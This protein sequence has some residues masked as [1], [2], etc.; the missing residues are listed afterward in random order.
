MRRCD[1]FIAFC[2]SMITNSAVMS[3]KKGCAASHPPPPPVAVG[4][5]SGSGSWQSHLHRH[6]SS[7]NGNG[8]SNGNMPCEASPDADSR[9]AGGKSWKLVY[10]YGSWRLEARSW[11][12]TAFRIAF[13]QDRG[14]RIEDQLFLSSIY[15]LVSSIQH[16]LHGSFAASGAATRR[17]LKSLNPIFSDPQILNPHILSHKKRMP[18]Y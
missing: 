14:S 3:S 8:N 2:L 18:Q 7:G 13:N 15:Y 6:H 16:Y 17:H 9:E 12:R 10:G 1:E 4:S 11:K 5:G